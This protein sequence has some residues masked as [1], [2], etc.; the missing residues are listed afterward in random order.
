MAVDNLRGNN[1]VQKNPM[2]DWLTSDTQMF[3]PIVSLEVFRQVSELIASKARPRTRQNLKAVYT[4]LLICENCGAAMTANRNSYS[5]TTYLNQGG[6]K[7]GCTHNII[8]QG[9]IDEYVDKWL[10]ATGVTLAWTD[11]KAPIKNFY[12]IGEINLRLLALRP[13]IDAIWL[14][15]SL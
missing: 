8:K 10:E 5:C 6:P 4:G 14:I 15:N 11:S 9:V 13:I 1:R 3:E 2:V 7:S 12:R